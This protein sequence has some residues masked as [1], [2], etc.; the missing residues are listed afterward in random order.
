MEIVY[1]KHFQ[2]MYQKL[3]SKQQDKVDETISL[4]QQ[5]PHASQ[6]HNHPLKGKQRGRRAISAGGDLRLVFIEHNEYSVVHFLTLGTHNQ[7]Y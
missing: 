5:T 2:K 7:V 1:H 3:T 6:L 4:F